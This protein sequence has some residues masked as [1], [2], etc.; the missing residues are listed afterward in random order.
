MTDFLEPWT[1]VRDQQHKRNVLQQVLENTRKALEKEEETPIVY[2][3]NNPIK[4]LID[5]NDPWIKILNQIRTKHKFSSYFP[6]TDAADRLA[7]TSKIILPVIRRMAATIMANDI[8]GVQPM[9]GPPSQ[10]FAL[11]ARYGEDYHL[12]I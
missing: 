3:S 5:E 7:E 6:R 11:H 9:S 2:S 8:I 12:K 1:K 4:E 10:I